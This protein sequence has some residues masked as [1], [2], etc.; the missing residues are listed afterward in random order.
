M[1][2]LANKKNYM[3]FE[4]PDNVGG[5]YSVLTAVGMVPLML[6]GHDVEKIMDGADKVFSRCEKIS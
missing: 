4:V 3:T 1:R 5:R 2:T 6:A